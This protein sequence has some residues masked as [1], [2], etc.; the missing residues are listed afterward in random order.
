MT[1]KM[2][3]TMSGNNRFNSFISSLMFWKKK[4]EPAQKEFYDENILTVGKLIKE[5]KKLDKNMPV[6]ECDNYTEFFP[7]MNL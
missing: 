1:K 2:T 5:L 4:D 7:F 6:G 3:K